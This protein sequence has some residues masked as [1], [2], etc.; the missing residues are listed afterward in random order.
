LNFLC[1]Y[2]GGIRLESTKGLAVR[3]R[4]CLKCIGM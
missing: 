2:F 1:V 3:G 4:G